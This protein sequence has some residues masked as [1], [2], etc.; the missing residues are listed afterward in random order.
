M[1]NTE[2]ATRTTI[3]G[4]RLVPVLLIEDNPADIRLTL[5]A[6]S[7]CGLT[8][9]E[10]I[11]DGDTALA[12]LR[13]QPPYQDAPRPGLVLL[14]L[15]L[16]GIDGRHV[17]TAIK[18]DPDL[19]TIPVII[20][21]TSSAPADIELAYREHA[22]CYLVKPLGFTALANTIE[23]ISAFWLD[24]R[25]PATHPGRPTMTA[26]APVTSQTPVAAAARPAALVR[27]HRRVGPATLDVARPLRILLIEDSPS[28]ARL[29]QERLR[30]SG[31][32]CDVAAALAEVTGR[33]LDAVDCALID[34]GLPDASGLQ[35]LEKV[36]EL[37]PQLPTVVLTG[38]DDEVTGLI[39]L[40]AGAQDYLVKQRAD[41]YDIARAVRFAVARKHLQLTADSQ[42][43]HELDLTDDVIQQLYA[44]GLAMSTS[45]RRTAQ[46]DPAMA[47]RI[48]G[49]MRALQD[50]VQSIRDNTAS[51]GGRPVR[52]VGRLSG[53]AV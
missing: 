4:R 11:T 38:L 53:R 10:V 25:H 19:H 16:P 39:A 34:L 40:R 36:R 20:L 46:K 48:A 12:Y 30:G 42:A 14:D 33:R 43:L 15:N 22:N 52:P 5:E 29:T 9:L 6:S 37:A 51:T 31:I 28:D 3:L 26:P 41:G 21:T 13:H 47:D 35:A 24:T 1:T 50:V 18:T 44:I 49:H 2:T 23:I 17:L 8:R 7:T 32:T 27:L 45:R